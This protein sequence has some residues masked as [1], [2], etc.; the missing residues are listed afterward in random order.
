MIKIIILGKGGQL[1]SELES[2][3]SYDQN[4]SFLSIG[5]L[6]ICDKDA[7]STYF[8]S[9]PCEVIINCAAY[10]A[11]DKAEEEKKACFNVNLN[12]VENLLEAI[13]G[14]SVRLIHISTDYVFDGEKSN[15][16][17]E[18]DFT[19]PTGIYGKSKLAGEKVISDSIAKSIIIRTSWLYSNYGDNF[20]KTMLK[21]GAERGEI[22]VIDDQ[23]G[24][25]TYANDLAKIII[26]IVEN[27][28]YNWSAGDVFHYSNE[29]SC[30]WHEF[31][32]EIFRISK[33]DVN[34]KKLTTDEF[35]TIAKRPKYS[36]LDKSKIKEVL[37]IKV[38]HWKISIN[39]MFKKKII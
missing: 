4:W 37:D 1:A 8:K 29:G 34:L 2:L 17:N 6:N 9:N 30:T 22:G 19:S 21:I 14:K 24:S 10:T 23:F 39:Q 11:V 5:K 3:K 35:P 32:S 15:P 33:I 25:P 12:G 18:T 31:A 38:P 36:L 26:K 7:V 13:Q 27:K 20:V 28:N 16:Y